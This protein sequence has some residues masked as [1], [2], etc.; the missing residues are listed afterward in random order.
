MDC[1]S[2]QERRERFSILFSTK[3]K[4][5]FGVRRR[6]NAEAQ[7]QIMIVRYPHQTRKAK[8]GLLPLVVMGP[9]TLEQ[10]VRSITSLRICGET[11]LASVSLRRRP[12]NSRIPSHAVLR[13]FSPSFATASLSFGFVEKQLC[14]GRMDRNSLNGGNRAVRSNDATLL[15]HP[16]Y[17]LSL[18]S[19]TFM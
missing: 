11:L 1:P 16:P 10:A 6:F 3:G 14:A 13:R 9:G 4:K 8:R 2:T 15:T 18:R 17:L 19:Q 12:G 7:I 5:M